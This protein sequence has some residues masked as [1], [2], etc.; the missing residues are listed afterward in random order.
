MADPSFALQVALVDRLEAGLEPLGCRVYD[1]APLNAPMP[2]VS[3]DSE[4]SNEADFLNSRMDERFLY[5]SVWSDFKGQQQVKELMAVIDD[6]LT[7]QPIT[8]TTGHVV[9]LQ[10]RRKQ[11]NREPDGETYQGAV[12][13]RIITQH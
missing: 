9:G 2:Y 1:G 12:T 3:I 13:L 7:R 10:V 5:L 4:I 6:V 11:S 8:L